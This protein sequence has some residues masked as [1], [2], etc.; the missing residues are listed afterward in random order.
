MGIACDTTVIPTIEADL[1][2]HTYSTSVF[3]CHDCLGN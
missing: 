3:Y 2:I 1:P